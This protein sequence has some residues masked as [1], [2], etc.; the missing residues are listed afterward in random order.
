MDS[1]HCNYVRLSI[2]PPVTRKDRKRVTTLLHPSD[3]NKAVI[4][5][6]NDKDPNL[7]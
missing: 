6:G 7:A 5:D 3:Q 4:S 1:I 2:A